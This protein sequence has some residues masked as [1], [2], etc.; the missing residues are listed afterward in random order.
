MQFDLYY[1]EKGSGFPLLLLHGNGED[2]TYFDHQMDHFSKMFRVIALDT[3]GHGRSPR[4]T[5]PFTISQFADDLLY[6]MDVHAIAR[7]HLLGFS[8]GGNIAI[9]FAVKYPER[10][11]RLVLNG[12]NLFPMG[13]KASVYWWVLRHY[14][15]AKRQRNLRKQE[16]LLLM[17]R[18]PHFTRC[19]LST[20]HNPTLVIVGNHDMIR[21]RHSRRIHDN[22]K[23]SQLHIIEGS[24]FCSKENYECFN[25]VVERFLLGE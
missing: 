3:R 20:I 6:F 23:N 13:M 19:M 25:Q 5:G 9:D 18:Q 15:R 2:H 21:E 22:I 7:A 10:V 11:A 16:R 4:G 17:L 12:A 14:W 1:E 24:H 8:D